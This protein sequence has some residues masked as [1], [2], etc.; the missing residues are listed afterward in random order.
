MNCIE[1]SNL[2]HRFSAKEVIL[3]KVNLTVSKGSVYGFLGPNGAGKTTTLKLIL[4]LI[5][6]QSGEISIFDEDIRNNRIAVLKRVGSML[7]SPSLYAHLTATENLKI[8]QKIYGVNQ[9]R[10]NEVLHM[11]GLEGTKSKTAGAFSL[12]MKQ[13]LGIASAMLHNPELLILDEPTNGLDPNGILEMRSLLLR[14]NAEFGLILMVSSHLLSE[15]EKMASHV[16]IIHQG[17]MKFEGKLETLT[18]QKENL[19]TTLFRCSDVGELKFFS[20]EK[21]VS[22]TKKTGGIAFQGLNQAEISQVNQQLV[23]YGISV[24]GIETQMDD[25]ESIFMDMISKSETL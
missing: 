8:W 25:L 18:L 12:G 7:E 22:Y 11:V 6:K 10:L 14:L 16:G 15:I 3:D 21:I 13:R 1:V 17:K 19:N 20:G 24:F 23:S 9:S 5:P 2:S 4:G